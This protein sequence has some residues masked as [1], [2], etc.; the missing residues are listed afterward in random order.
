MKGDLEYII[1][2]LWK[3]CGMS[4]FFYRYPGRKQ[5]QFS[6]F[7]DKELLQVKG[8]GTHSL[9]QLFHDHPRARFRMEEMEP[10]RSSLERSCLQTKCFIFLCGNHNRGAH[11]TN[12]HK[13]LTAI[14]TSFR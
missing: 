10:P 1:Q 2:D 5:E 4:V 6:G 12:L 11:F 13:E 14:F 8:T 7:I 3:F 9:R